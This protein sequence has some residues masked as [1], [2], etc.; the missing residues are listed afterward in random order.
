MR[1]ENFC[2]ACGARNP[3]DD[4][5]T[6]R[7]PRTKKPRS[8]HRAAGV[9]ARYVVPERKH[10]AVLFA[11][12]CG[13][14]QRVSKSDP[15]DARR[16]LKEALALMTPAVD[17]YEGTSQEQ[18][19]GVIALFGA[20]AA[21]EDYVL[22]ACLAAQDIQ[23]RTAEWNREADEKHS[24]NLRVGIDCGEVV[25]EFPTSQFRVDGE[26][27]HTAKRLESAAE[28]GTIYISGA[29]YRQAA[30][31][32]EARSLGLR[33]FKGL[34][35][36]IDVYQLALR[37][38]AA[39]LARWRSP[40]TLVGRNELLV[41][42]EAIAAQ[43][44]P[45]Q[46]RGVGLRGEAGAGK[47]RLIAEFLEVQHAQG[48]GVCFVAAHAYAIRVQYAVAADLMRELLAIAPHL[49][50]QRQ[51]EAVRSAVDG[52]TE[53]ERMHRAAAVDLLGLGDAGSAWLGLTPNQRRR[54][55]GEALHWLVA[56]RVVAGP[57]LIVIED[58]ALADRESQRLL[59]QLLRRIEN[60]P[61]LLCTSYR[62]GYQPPWAEASWFSELWV[63]LLERGETRA[64]ARELLGTH[65]SLDA[66]I[67]E[68][69]EKADGNPF[70]L[71]QMAMTLIDRGTLVGSPGAYRCVHS[72]VR[73]LIPPTIANV[74]R[75][76]LDRL[77]PAVK[78]TLEAAAILG[79][80]FSSELLAAM[81]NQPVAEIEDHLSLA[82]A[83][84]LL[85]VDGR[86]AGARHG[87]RHALVQE[88]IA[89]AL[90]RSRKSELHRAALGALRAQPEA[91]SPDQSAVLA[92]HAFNGEAWPEAAD[93]A[94]QSMSRSIA[95]SAN[96]EA[97]VIFE[98]GM[99][100][101][102]RIAIEP[103]R[104][105]LE[106]DLLQ[107]TLGA[108]LPLGRVDEILENLGRAGAI[109]RRLGNARHQA[110]VQL[111]LAVM[112]WT[113]GKYTQG[114]EAAREASEAAASAGSRTLKMVAAQARMMLNHG[115]G[116][117]AQ[118]L[119]DA[120]AVER[121]FAAELATRRIMPGWAV[122]PALNVKVFLADVMKRMGNFDAAEQACSAAYRE[123][124]GNEHA[125]SRSLVD[126]VQGTL[127]IEQGR[128]REAVALL[129]PALQHCYA[130]DIPTMVPPIYAA[131]Y[132]ALAL[133]G[134]AEEAAARLRKAVA[135]KLYLAGGRY[136]EFYLSRSLAIALAELGRFDEARAAAEVARA[137]ATS[138]GQRGHEAEALTT[139]A[140]IEAKSGHEPAARTYFEQARDLAQRCSASLI[141][142]RCT[143]RL[144][145]LGAAAAVA[146]LN[147]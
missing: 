103:R 123:L 91:A 12:V 81:R 111:Q 97:L 95:R 133:S 94:R 136:N 49:D 87:F 4:A 43:V 104:L 118:V 88:A 8:E 52:W 20:P 135:D 146:G 138:F 60:L 131:L 109:A 2:P 48:F 68:L 47:S 134:Q 100:A 66:A 74:I 5:T 79:D 23:R 105:E 96:R 9:A 10:V 121:E 39:P 125:F 63:R 107:E 69:V 57:L 78:E 64:I 55:I 59:E 124:D 1:G 28:P 110:S 24:I 84:G 75:S 85:S 116:L 113:G 19:D 76:R 51:L 38:A 115:L 117:Y 7:S 119:A 144:Q 98:L 122:L 14:T 71:E 92:H 54:R 37:S 70:Y 139:L 15:E 17:A 11:D 145:A 129:R 41:A 101:A 26:A 127:W 90:V 27:V 46:L 73:V 67:D 106:L 42:L 93:Y 72:N 142:R 13:S 53:P 56:K 36:A 128:A 25:V 141:E 45:R 30:P 130:N 18:G 82:A 22:R 21:Q 112:F 50:V 3:V 58:L 137:S 143:E 32:L 83:A 6:T 33:E 80:A 132:R 61:V 65:P 126:F 99:E 147:G 86:P 35:T 108:L 34:A 16:Y 29:V 102:R 40:A 120:R 62:E 77:P 114:L 31:W 140:E 44:R 89:S